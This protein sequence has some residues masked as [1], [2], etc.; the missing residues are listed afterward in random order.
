MCW[1]CS[2]HAYSI[3]Q[4][5][6]ITKLWSA[7]CVCRTEVVSIFHSFRGKKIQGKKNSSQYLILSVT[8]RNVLFSTAA[9][10][11]DSPGFQKTLKAGQDYSDGGLN[12]YLKLKYKQ[13]NLY[14]VYALTS[15]E[16]HQSA[17]RCGHVVVLAIFSFTFFHAAFIK[18]KCLKVFGKIARVC[19]TKKPDQNWCL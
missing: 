7:Q 17:T 19:L 12:W 16:L 18:I 3:S 5:R 9:L 4:I 8:E 1:Q 6:V 11:H 13:L 14:L 10:S 15:N 2:H